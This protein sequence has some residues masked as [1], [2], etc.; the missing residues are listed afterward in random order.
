ME[1]FGPYF[2]LPKQRQFINKLQFHELMNF[3]QICLLCVFVSVHVIYIQYFV[4]FVHKFMLQ[5]ALDIVVAFLLANINELFSCA[6][7]QKY[8]YPVK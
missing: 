2:C 7:K 1:M 5:L 4:R 6:Q 8:G 3:A